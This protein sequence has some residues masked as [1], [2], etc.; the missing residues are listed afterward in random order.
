MIY[1]STPVTGSAAHKGPGRYLAAG[2]G[3]G[4]VHEPNPI[5]VEFRR[6]CVEEWDIRPG[7]LRYYSGAWVDLIDEDP[8]LEDPANWGD[9]RRCA[10][11]AQ[12]AHAR[13]VL[14]RLTRAAS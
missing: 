12:V 2:V 3:W 9:M 10:T 7:Q 1:A 11:P 6:F 13:L 5:L 14:D 8:E 4:R